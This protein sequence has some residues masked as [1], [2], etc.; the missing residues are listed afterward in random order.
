MSDFSETL[1][2]DVND[3]NYWG[4]TEN[5]VIDPNIPKRLQEFDITELQDPHAA[6]EIIEILQE[7]QAIAGK[8]KPKLARE[9]QEGLDY[10]FE[11]Y[12]EFE[13]NTQSNAFNSFDVQN[14]DQPFKGNS[15][16]ERIQWLQALHHNWLTKQYNEDN[17]VEIIDNPLGEGHVLQHEHI[18]LGLVKNDLDNPDL[19]TSGI[20]TFNTIEDAKK[21]IANK[22]LQ[23][24][25]SSTSTD[26]AVTANQKTSEIFPERGK[27]L[28]GKQLSL[29]D[30]INFINPEEPTETTFPV[31]RDNFTTKGLEILDSK[32]RWPKLADEAMSGWT[33]MQVAADKGFTSE[34]I[35]A[36][37]VEYR[38]SQKDKGISIRVK[39]VEFD[40]FNQIPNLASLEIVKNEIEKAPEETKE[41]LEGKI[42]SV[43]MEV[44]RT[45]FP[46]LDLDDKTAQ[47]AGFTYELLKKGTL[48]Q[49]DW[50]Y[51]S[52]KLIEQ[53][54][55]AKESSIREGFTTKGLE[56]LDS[57]KRWPKLANE[58]MSGWTAMQMAI[59]KG[60][61]PNIRQKEKG[62]TEYFLENEDNVTV[63]LKKVEFDL[64]TKLVSSNKDNRIVKN[65]KMAETSKPDKQDRIKQLLADTWPT[66][67]AEIERHE[68]L[69]TNAKTDIQKENIADLLSDLKENQV[70]AEKQMKSLGYLD[71]ELGSL[72]KS[73]P[74]EFNFVRNLYAEQPA[75][76]PEGT[77][78]EIQVTG[79]NNHQVIEHLFDGSQKIIKATPD[80]SWT[81][82]QATEEA[83]K[84]AGFVKSEL[85]QKS[86]VESIQEEKTVTPKADDQAIHLMDFKTFLFE[87]HGVDAAN[88]GGKERGSQT[89]IQEYIK[90]WGTAVSQAIEEG[91][92]VPELNKKA[93]QS[94][95]N[96]GLFKPDNTQ[97]ENATEQP[98][99][100]SKEKLYYDYAL[101]HPRGVGMGAS[102]PGHVQYDAEL[103]YTPGGS[104]VFLGGVVT[105]DKPLSAEEVSH[106]SYI[107][108]GTRT[109]LDD[110]PDLPG[111][112]S[113]E[114][115]RIGRKALP[116]VDWP[117]DVAEDL[118]RAYK[119]K[120]AGLMSLDQWLDKVE[121]Y[122]REH[123]PVA[124]KDSGPIYASNLPTDAKYNFPAAKEWMWD[125]CIFLGKFEHEGQ[126]YDLGVHAADVNNP[127]A[128][129]VFDN[130]PGSYR[131]NPLLSYL[132]DP[133][134]AETNR[135]WEEYKLENNIG[136]T[137][138]NTTEPVP[139]AEKNYPGADNW[140]WNREN[141]TFLGKFEYEGKKYDLGVNVDSNTG[142]VSAA[143]VD[144]NEPGNYQSGALDNFIDNNPIYEETNRRWI[145]HS[146]TQIERQIEEP[147]VTPKKAY[148]MTKDE[149]V[150]Q[151]GSID[152]PN[153]ALAIYVSTFY[154]DSDQETINK[155]IEKGLFASPE[156]Y[157]HKQVVK[158][159][160]NMHVDLSP[161]VMADYPDLKIPKPELWE[162]SNNEILQEPKSFMKKSD[163]DETQFMKQ[164]IAG[165][166]HKTAVT[167]A[168]EEGL[169][170]PDKAIEDHPE[171]LQVNESGPRMR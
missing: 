149:F 156:E 171:L 99:K 74:S 43:R 19:S 165:T 121:I 67:A 136:T 143:I 115:Q 13:K 120:K 42:Q 90:E 53:N 100:T 168:I 2:F 6:L 62:P 167:Q 161:A 152:N 127:D 44:G 12:P 20:A 129:I 130:K 147:Y 132:K 146:A 134:F 11:L 33:A 22:G 151:I 126:K 101:I 82:Q 133:V 164:L 58:A 1:S 21:A 107:A 150:E 77:V 61:K 109:S 37:P 88:L 110:Q 72:F 15:R 26:S 70:A 45:L 64:Y 93:L 162:A 47:E 155:K 80:E 60:F 128:A 79:N 71:E 7:E 112:E 163:M 25:H 9:I 91:K 141:N 56:I 122:T 54:K 94:A 83:I 30:N 27:G 8:R 75:K 78:F 16:E 69:V 102:P 85:M 117:D 153:P 5:Y 87:I 57:E 41:E 131:S 145:E 166:L 35:E 49:N 104:M 36:T 66:P 92:E 105:Y 84:A 114:F 46:D 63:R 55:P 135:R 116:D 17:R 89:E 59:D 65:E 50:D 48:N 142:A 96:Q 124:S 119:E 158:E 169:P 139:T 73:L 98:A 138:K 157:I 86:S 123:G 148:E 160:I 137:S 103:T 113:R 38:I 10:L 40:L 24:V 95:I 29:F 140:M 23:E 154:P 34:K 14:L 118:G 81:L 170:V 111:Y 28:V 159:A 125:K 3:D 68:V 32:K 106:Y 97:T 39:K 52:S 76:S 108:I 31:S 144:G 18:E 4:N 51:Y